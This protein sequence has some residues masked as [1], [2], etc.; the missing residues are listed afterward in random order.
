MLLSSFSFLKV[1]A[2]PKSESLMLESPS[3]NRFS[4]FKSLKNQTKCQTH[5]IRK[6]HHTWRTTPDPS[7]KLTKKST[8][9]NAPDAMGKNSPMA[10]STRVKE[11]QSIAHLRVELSGGMLAEGSTS[12]NIAQHVATASQFHHHVNLSKQTDVRH[13]SHLT[14]FTYGAV[15]TITAPARATLLRNCAT[16]RLT[17]A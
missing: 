2:K 9:M 6:S 7:C 5:N 12:S 3:N 8:K 13:T 11:L 4:H 16:Q 1:R 17:F 10:N 15:K 14:Y